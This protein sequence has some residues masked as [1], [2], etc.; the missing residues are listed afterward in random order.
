MKKYV[1]ID[2]PEIGSYIEEF[3][4]LMGALAAEFDGLEEYAEL[5]DIITLEVIGMEEEEYN[6]LPEFKGW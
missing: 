3:S 2:R 5:G 1:K 6:N 4:N